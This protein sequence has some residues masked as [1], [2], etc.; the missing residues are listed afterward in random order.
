MYSINITKPASTAASVDY[1]GGIHS[2]T[3]NNYLSPDIL[4]SVHSVLDHIQPGPD[5]VKAGTYDAFRVFS[6][7]AAVSLPS[8][9]DATYTFQASFPG[10]IKRYISFAA[11]DSWAFRYER[12]NDRQATAAVR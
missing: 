3:S 1:R 11:I 10:N 6:K 12:Q 2:T 9:D 8:T 4:R 7:V 5:S